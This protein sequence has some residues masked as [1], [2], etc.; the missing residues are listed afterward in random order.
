MPFN[1]FPRADGLPGLETVLPKAQQCHAHAHAVM[2]VGRL[3]VPVCL[4]SLLAI[5]PLPVVVGKMM[6]HSYIYFCEYVY[7]SLG[8]TARIWV[9]LR[10]I[11]DSIYS[12]YS[13]GMIDLAV[14]G[15][16]SAWSVW[17]AWS[18][19]CGTGSRTQTR[20]CIAASYC[21]T[22]C[23]GSTINTQTST[24]IGAYSAWVSIDRDVLVGVSFH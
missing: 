22:G 14:A 9:T 4:W 24:T 5:Q 1:S 12:L 3:C 7:H 2:A 10:F 21:N 15:T 13:T 17:G 16:W 6:S 20:T 8:L 19:G 18:T 11:A 23:A